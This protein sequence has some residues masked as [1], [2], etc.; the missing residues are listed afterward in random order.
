MGSDDPSQRA[1]TRQAAKWMLGLGIVLVCG[2]LWVWNQE[3][4]N[5]DAMWHLITSRLSSRDRS[6][7][8]SRLWWLVSDLGHGYVLTIL[9]GTLNVH[10]GS[11]RF[12]QDAVVLTIGSA[13]ATRLLKVL[14]LRERPFEPDPFSWPS[15]HATASLAVALALLPRRGA[16]AAALPLALVAGVARVMHHRHWPSDVLGGYG[17]ALAVAAVGLR[18]PLFLPETL[19]AVRTRVALAAGMLAFVLADLG[20]GQWDEANPG[21]L[22]MLAAPLAVLAAAHGC[23]L[24]RLAR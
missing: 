11:R 9:I 2:S 7:P 10:L 4:Q 23:V 14:V 19:V 20:L 5:G 12:L 21:Y 1:T 13:I 6:L 24:A 17:V 8:A 3:L 16:F 22:P 15:G 18:L